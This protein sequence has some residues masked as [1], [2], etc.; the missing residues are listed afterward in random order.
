M[1][2]PFL[3]I[4]LALILGIASSSAFS[5][6][7]VYPL[8]LSAVFI[9]SAV[10]FCAKKIP[11][12]VSLY[13]AIF[14]FG[15]AYYLESSTLPTDHVSGYQS[16]GPK[17]IFLK[18]IV[19]DDPLIEMGFQNRAKTVFLL[20]VR[21][22][23]DAEEWLKSSGSVVV[24][25]YSG[26]PALSFG[27]EVLVEGVLSEP[28]ALRNPGVFDYSKYLRMKGVYSVFRV[29]PN[30]PVKIISPAAK[31]SVQGIAY[32]LRHSAR[33][34]IDANF[35]KKH[36]GFLKSI[37]IGDR[38]ELDDGIKEDFV[39]TGTVHVLAISGLH[40]AFVAAIFMAVFGVLRIPRKINVV[41][42]A[43]LLVFYAFATGANPPI[44]RAVVMFVFFAA[45]YLIGRESGG[46]NT[47]SAAAFIMLMYDPKV[48]LDPSFQLSFASV[49]SVIIFTPRI[50]KA[51]GSEKIKARGFIRKAALFLIAGV[52]VS[53]AAWIGSFPLVASY[54]NIVSPVSF[55]A[56]LLIVPLLSALTTLSFVFLPAQFFFSHLGDALA[57]LMV[58]LGD[59]LFWANHIMASLPF[60][61]FRVQSP[62][63]YLCVIFY[64]AAFSTFLPRKKQ[65]LLAIL[66]LCNAAVWPGA[67][68]RAKSLEVIF[69][70]VGQGDSAFISTQSG[71]AILI[72]GSTG[73]IEGGFD[74]GRSVI[75]PYLWN[76]G[77][78]RIDA[79]IVTHFHEDHV[80]GLIYV[81][82]NFEVGCV[83]DS[84]ADAQDSPLYHKY[85]RIL[86]KRKIRHLVVRRGDTIGP[87]GDVMFYVLNPDAEGRIKDSNENSIVLKMVSSNLSVL[88]CAD[89]TG[90]AIGDVL[91]YGPFLISDV[92]KVPHHGGNLGD[93]GNV[94]YFF[95]T[96]SAQAAVISVGRNNRYKAPS[97]NTV[98]AVLSS[99]AS[100]YETKDSGSVSVTPDKYGRL[101]IMECRKKI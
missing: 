35:D 49:G 37:I 6:P 14:F 89:I 27:D 54:F 3:Y 29:D 97:K 40:V 61:Y 33:R 36:A 74:I 45:A 88:F 7:L 8:I 83:I 72:D 91:D 16:V 24:T 93:P 9:S 44:I 69:L 98:E 80:G 70:D 32:R 75:A 38:S 95:N 41:L 39:R 57:W 87:F 66:I 56:N 53:A 52:S 77:V 79:V 92:I 28:S 50:M 5:P 90:E 43:V 20:K 1:K 17:K 10:V 65:V 21:A 86:R 64:L 84:G 42:T 100:V 62:S 60:A 101:K 99:G 82:D 68:P 94:N 85:R 4:T 13:L 63:L 76:R 46:T 11:S 18:G 23:S 96:V 47:L 48:L 19:S 78:F 81:L 30:S 59:I 71:A 15:M 12:H 73:G 67:I 34:A 22:V 58:F 2:R 26:D 55:V 31:F 25:A 51:L